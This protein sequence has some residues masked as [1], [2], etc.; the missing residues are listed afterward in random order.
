MKKVILAILLVG[1]L[2]LFVA[3]DTQKTT[4]DPSTDSPAILVGYDQDHSKMIFGDLSD[5][6]IQDI[7]G[8]ILEKASSDDYEADKKDLIIEEVFKES[9]IKDEDM[10][11]AAKVKITISK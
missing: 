11:N 8:K 4:P 10:I 9:G 3:C 6:E 1:S 2:S 5:E 7:V